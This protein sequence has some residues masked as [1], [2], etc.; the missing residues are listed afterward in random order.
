VGEAE[1]GRTFLY[2]ALKA[3]TS[4]VESRAHGAVL[5]DG[6]LAYPLKIKNYDDLRPTNLAVPRI[7]IVVLI[8]AEIEDW[9]SQSEAALELR[10]CAYWMSLRGEPGVTN[11]TTKTVHVPRTQVFGS[12]ALTAILDRIADGGVP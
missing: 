1:V 6:H 3:V 12:D 5:G 2:Y 7:L 9:T 4:H 8:P 11:E 10:R